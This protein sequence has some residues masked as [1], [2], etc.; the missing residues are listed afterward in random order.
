VA[1][2]TSREFLDIARDSGQSWQAKIVLSGRGFDQM[3]ETAGLP[4]AI[5]ARRVARK[6]GRALG[7]KQLP[8]LDQRLVQMERVF[9]A[10]PLTP[11]LISEIRLISPHCD[12]APSERHKPIA[13]HR[14]LRHAAIPGVYS[15]TR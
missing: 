3:S 1:L 14:A 15:T 11:E 8:E 5:F 6:L 10:P 12:L 4:P 13:D 9:R 2:A 7:M